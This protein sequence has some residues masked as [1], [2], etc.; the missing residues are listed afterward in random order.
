[1]G[2]VGPEPG[3]G[4]EE[5]QEMGG[6]VHTAQPRRDPVPHLQAS[7]VCVGVGG[8]EDEGPRGQERGSKIWQQVP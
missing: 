6:P 3:G 4:Q 8:T 5:R 1:M 2:R 7:G